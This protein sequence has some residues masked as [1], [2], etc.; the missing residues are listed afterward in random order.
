MCL[1][2]AR[3]LLQTALGA[4]GGSLVP[5][6]MIS[7]SWGGT[8]IQPWMPE[9]AIAQCADAGHD[10]DGTLKSFRARSHH[11]PGLGLLGEGA[12]CGY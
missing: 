6:G 2:H 3:E 8:P 4:P 11:D 7:S 5:I 9:E 10:N 12:A 1:Y